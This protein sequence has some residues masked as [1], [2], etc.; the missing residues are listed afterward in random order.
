[1]VLFDQVIEIFGLADFDGRFTI[2]I[3]RFERGRIGA[4]LSVVTVSGTPV[5][6][7]AFSK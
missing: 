6:A 5:W 1:M 2:G 3:D 7:I 4:A